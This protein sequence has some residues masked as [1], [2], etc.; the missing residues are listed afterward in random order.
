MHYRTSFAT[1]LKASEPFVLK[2]T[3]L[4][5]NEPKAA[6]VRQFRHDYLNRVRASQAWPGL[7][8]RLAGL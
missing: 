6:Q 7:S 1:H 4:S 8:Y 5:F 2:F 3:P